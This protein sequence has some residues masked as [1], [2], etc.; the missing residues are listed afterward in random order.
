[1]EWQSRIGF[2]AEGLRNNTS[3]GRFNVYIGS[4]DLHTIVILAERHDNPGASI[5][6]AYEAYANA[7]CRAEGLDPEKCLF[8]E[9]YVDPSR[10]KGN[11]LVVEKGGLIGSASLDRVHIDHGGVD[12]HWMPGGAVAERLWQSLRGTVPL[13]WSYPAP[14]R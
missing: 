4:T 10:R 9:L 14:K 8:Y 2:E 6:N 3:V 5:T 12:T 1:M 13:G 7:V 11:E